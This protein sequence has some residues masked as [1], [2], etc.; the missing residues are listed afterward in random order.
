[1]STSDLDHSIRRPS[2]QPQTQRYERYLYTY[3]MLLGT[4]PLQFLISVEPAS[5]KHARGKVSFHLSLKANGVERPIGEPT[6]MNLS[7]DPK[8]LDFVIFAFPGNPSL[9]AGCQYSLRVWLRANNVDHRLFGED[10]IWIGKDP[11][12]STIRDASFARLKSVDADKQIYHGLV[13]KALVNFVVRW[14][15]FG[16]GL[17]KY[18]MEYEAGGAGGT[19]FEDIRM[20]FDC[21]PKTITFLIYTVPMESKPP[22]GTHRLRVWLRT[23]V[24]LSAID[25]SMAHPLPF[26]DSY[27]YQRIYRSDNLRIGGRLDFASLSQ[28]VITGF[29]SGPP[30]VITSDAPSSRHSSFDMKPRLSYDGL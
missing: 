6:T 27:V 11:D 30:Q 25:P 3:N 23:L 17:Y 19:I 15:Y 14:R 26:N 21:D 13:G 8:A 20:R 7:L 2:R 18:S 28:K 10:G 1:M 29:A 22:G 24:N 12:F 9:P 4:T 16:E 5:S